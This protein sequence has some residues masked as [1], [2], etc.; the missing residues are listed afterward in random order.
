MPISFLTFP[1]S[2]GSERNPKSFVIPYGKYTGAKARQ[3]VALEVAL[4]VTLE[5]PLSRLK[6]RTEET[7]RRAIEASETE[8]L[9][10]HPG[11]RRAF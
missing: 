11:V 8:L 3:T 10:T 6:P 9:G 4:E 2:V 1:E 7:R 5:V